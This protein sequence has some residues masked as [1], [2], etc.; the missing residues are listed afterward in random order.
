MK[1]ISVMIK[2]SSGM[3][4]MHCDY[5]FYN[6]EMRNRKQANYGFMSEETLRNVIRRTLTKADYRANYIFQGGEP[7]LRGL[8]FFQEV[9]K[10]EKQYNRNQVFVQNYLQTNGTLIDEEW[11]HF[12]HDNQFLVGISIDGL[13]FIHDRHRKSKKDNGPTFNRAFHATELMNRYDVNYNILTV[14]HKDVADNIERIYTAY[15]QYGWKYQQYIACLDPLG[16]R[17][18]ETDYSLTPD[19]YKR[20]LIQLFELWYQDALKGKQPYIRQFEN[21]IGILMKV[22]PEACDQ[23]GR[24]NIQYAVEADGSVF[25]CDFYMTDEFYLG[26]FNHDQIST[27]DSKREETGFIEKSLRLNEQ[28]RNCTYYLLCGGGCQRNRI[29]DQFTESYVNTYCSSFRGFFDVCLPRMKKLISPYEEM[30]K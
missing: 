22:R 14:V 2:P 4:N 18:G 24:C 23:T 30:K 25:P 28:C 29:I 7:T 13:Q 21:Y 3:C 12:L 9:I 6:D 19:A 20:F 26:N 5:C 17:N 15:H 1:S 10:L 8:R 11:C 16:E 27:I